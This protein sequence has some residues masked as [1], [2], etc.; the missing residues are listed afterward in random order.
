MPLRSGG[1]ALGAAAWTAV[2]GCGP[3]P[4]ETRV[5]IGQIAGPEGQEGRIRV[6]LESELFAVSPI[7]DDGA[8]RV[9][10]PVGAPF[11]WAVETPGGSVPM[12]VDGSRVCVEG[13]PFDVG[14]WA[15]RPCF[16]DPDACLR[17]IEEVEGCNRDCELTRAVLAWTC[18][19]VP[20]CSG[21]VFSPPYRPAECLEVGP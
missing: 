11:R 8:F 7:E 2:F 21:P 15:I 14:T 6:T 3:A 10:L 13:P 12:F 16:A 4:A 19:D 1:L 9:A 18:S 20:N 17:A 5:A